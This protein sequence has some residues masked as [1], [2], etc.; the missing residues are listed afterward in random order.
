MRNKFKNPETHAIFEL[1]MNLKRDS[2][3]LKK[4]DK[5]SKIPS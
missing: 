2:I 3:L 4:S 5:L 1:S